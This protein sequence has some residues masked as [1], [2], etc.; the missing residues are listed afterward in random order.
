MYLS[1]PKQ[2][3]KGESIEESHTMKSKAF[4]N[5]EIRYHRLLIKF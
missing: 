4:G 3:K 5:F 2:C 1:L